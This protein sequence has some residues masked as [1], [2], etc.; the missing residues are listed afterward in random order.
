MKRWGKLNPP[1]FDESEL[2]TDL[3][4]DNFIFVGSSCDMFANGIDPEWAVRTLGHCFKFDNQ[5]LF[6]SKN[7]FAFQAGILFPKK[8]VYCTTIETNRF[9]KE[10]MGSTIKP[11][12]RAYY[13]P[14]GNYLTIEPIMDFDLTPFLTLINI[15][16]PKQIN[17]GADSG[18]NNLP[19]PPKEK[20]LELITE[21]SLLRFKQ[22]EKDL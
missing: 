7:P 10:I 1:R 8:S 13:L 6:Q 12:E 16:A 5:Y 2:K 4:K 14:T 21:T 9:Y 20:I 15:T 11:Q 19:E 17:I 22:T 18:N 3:G